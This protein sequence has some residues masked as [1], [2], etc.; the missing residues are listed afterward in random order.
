MMFLLLGLGGVL[1]AL[2]RYHGARIVQARISR[3]FP[4]GTLLINLSGSALL[5]AL[6][7]VL[8]RHPTWPRQ[9]LSLLWGTGFC[10]AYTTFSSWSFETVQLWR[11]GQ[12]R[13]ALINVLTQP[14]LGGFAAWLGLLVGGTI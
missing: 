8:A 1:G 5:G 3:N 9:E 13:D 6:I 4:L 12:R 2:C 7:G 11:E 10:G 14:L